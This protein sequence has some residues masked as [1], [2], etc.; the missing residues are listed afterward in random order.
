MQTKI[1]KTDMKTGTR[2]ERRESEAMSEV[3]LQELRIAVHHAHHAGIIDGVEASKLI[4]IIQEYA[5]AQQ[6][7]KVEIVV[8]DERGH[9]TRYPATPIG[10]RISGGYKTETYVAKRVVSDEGLWEDF[11]ETLDEKVREMMENHE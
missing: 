8:K 6:G 1:T 3:N 5:A 7:P 10:E 2:Q 11:N 9:E 4:E